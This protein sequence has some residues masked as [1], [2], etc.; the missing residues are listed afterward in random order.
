MRRKVR[1]SNASNGRKF[2]TFTVYRDKI[3]GSAS[4]LF[5]AY[6]GSFPGRGVDHSR[7]PSVWVRNDWRYASDFRK[8]KWQ[9]AGEPLAA[10]YNW[11]QDPAPG[12]GPAVEKRWPIKCFCSSPGLAFS[13][14]P[15]YVSP[16]D[17]YLTHTYQLQPSW[18]ALSLFLGCWYNCQRVDDD[19]LNVRQWGYRKQDRQ[20]TWRTE[21][22]EGVQ[23]PL[24]KFRKPSKIVPSSTR[25]WKLLKIAEFRTPTP[26]HV[27]KKG[28]K[29]IK[30]PRI[31]H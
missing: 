17:S 5:N 1:D 22:G 2:S 6:R 27:R 11:C 13:S 10:R 12:R 24:P 3:Y 30:L 31:A 16:N 29:I 23:P 4:L 18:W 25:L 15:S 21:G 19:L 20:C 7:T 28:S 26:Q 8:L 9:I 14:Y